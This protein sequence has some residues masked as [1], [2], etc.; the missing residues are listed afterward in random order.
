MSAAGLILPDN[1]KAMILLNSLPHSYK[2]IISTIIQTT[3]A[4][5]FTMEHMI[6]LIIAE[7]QLRHRPDRDL[8]CTVFSRNPQS[9]STALPP[10]NELHTQLRFVLTARRITL[11]TTV[12]KCMAVPVNALMPITVE[13]SPLTKK[14][15]HL[16]LPI[17]VP[18]KNRT[19]QETIKVKALRHGSLTKE[20]HVQMK[21]MLSQMR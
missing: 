11:L 5:N 1:L 7:S 16:F 18:L 10:F 13:V 19:N 8:L 20:R 21:L 6:P 4:A 3:T 17:L 2:S 14:G 12:G 15:N 9:K